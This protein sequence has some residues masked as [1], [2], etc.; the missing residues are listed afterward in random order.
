ME[1]KNVLNSNQ[2]KV[3]IVGAGFV[4]STA[5]YALLLDGIV[6]EIAL[7]DKD[8]KKAE[9][10]ALDLMHGM[11]FTQ[12]VRISAGDSF[13]LV[14]DAKIV[15]L[16]P[17]IA[18]KIGQSRSELLDV[19]VKI[20]KEIIPQI[21]KYNKDCILLIVTNPLDVLTY[22]AYKLSGFSA[23]RV[24]GTGTVLDTARLRY[25][26][27][28]SLKIS[29]KDITA[30]ILGEHGD[31]QFVWWSHANIAGIPIYK[32]PS[33]S[34]EFLEQIYLN[35]KSAVYDVISRKG[36]TY[37]SIAL[38]VAKI[39]KA[40]LLDQYRVF[41]VSTV[42]HDY[43]GASNICL[44]VPTIVRAGGICQRFDI[45]LSD[46]EKINFKNCVDK[47]SSELEKTKNI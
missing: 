34:N 27:G 47:V 33:C 15:V 6:S 4:G 8:K 21:V 22:L 1:N 7:I 44:S 26:L 32:V 20:F 25:L 29:P 5:A 39:V 30:Y 17:G 43:H 40:I 3:A 37:Y 11:Q 36:A 16:S 10:H 23:C 2:K 24:F 31:S 46:N 35:V 9:G 28:S 38:V 14:K 42:L 19:N 45:D 13:E 12:S 18:Q 41:T